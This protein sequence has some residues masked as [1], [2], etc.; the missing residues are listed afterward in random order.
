M[1]RN[2]KLMTLT[3][4]IWNLRYIAKSP[5][6]EDGGFHE[7]AVRCAKSALHYLKQKGKGK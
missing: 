1:K 7:Q 5:P 3:D 6:L 2:K 4:T